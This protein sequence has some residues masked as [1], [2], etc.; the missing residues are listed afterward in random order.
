M[1]KKKNDANPQKL[2][3]EK[4][5]KKLSEK[6]KGNT[7]KNKS[8][9]NGQKKSSKGGSKPSNKET[10]KIIP[11][12]GLCEIGKNMTAFEYKDDMII[13]DC[14]MAFPEENMPGIDCV[15]QDYSYVRQNLSKLRGILITHGHE[16]HI[17]ALPFFLSEFNCPV[18]GGH[19]TI[20]LIKHKLQ[21]KGVKQTGIKMTVLKNGDKVKL[22]AFT[23]EFIRVNHSIA[24]SYAVAIDTP[25]GMIVHSG[26]F[27]IDFT[28]I[29]GKTIDL[30]R[31]GELGK[32][33]VLLFMCESTNVEIEGFSKSEKSVGKSFENLFREASGRIIVATFSSHVHRMQQIFTAAEK[34]NRKVCLSGRSMEQ[35]FHIANDM[36]YI[37]MRPNTLIDIGSI[38]NYRDNELVIMTTGSQAEPMSAL[39]RMAFDSHKA[40]DISKG[41]TVIISAD[42]IPGNEKPIYRVINEL[43]K[44][45]A[46]VIYA[47]LADVHVSGHAYRNELMLLHTLIKPKFFIPIHG[48]YRMLHLHK[49]LA[50]SLGVPSDNIFVLNNGDVL[51]LS[52]KGGKVTDNVPAD[53]VLID[54]MATGH[55][56]DRILTD[57]IH[58]AQDGVVAV[59]FTVD[60]N[61]GN[62]LCPPAVNSIGFNYDEDKIALNNA[63]SD[64]CIRLL[65]DSSYIDATVEKRSFREHLKS[66][67]S[68]R[69]GRSPMLIFTVSH[70]QDDMTYYGDQ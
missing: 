19:L 42:P 46:N 2:K 36:G 55:V 61:T 31:F 37:D 30:Q 70:A 59:A 54:G 22:G 5:L 16:D 24:D 27:K 63:I 40:I 34:Y 33:G 50:E 12:G 7:S 64:K 9:K 3:Q 8:Q 41:D 57:R 4:A 21:D 60:D 51:S 15:I 65:A 62:L 43:Y 6:K 53:A 69:T 28:P 35:V 52:S 38:D 49:E 47:S 1:S 23:C 25:V 45:G 66:F 10:V 14:G 39:S 26:D 17:G 44:K 18:Y 58:L 56:N 20:E 48:E 29:N 11:L 67:I 68:S 32:N 13:V